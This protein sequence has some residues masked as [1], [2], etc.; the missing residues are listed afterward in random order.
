[1]LIDSD[2]GNAS[3]E[4]KFEQEAVEK[5]GQTIN[6]MNEKGKKQLIDLAYRIETRTPEKN[7]ELG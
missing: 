7:I 2:R 6:L 1:M 3:E 4:F 5:E